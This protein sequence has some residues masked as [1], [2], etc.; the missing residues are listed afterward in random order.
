MKRLTSLLL[1]LLLLSGLTGCG[2]V[3]VIGGADGPTGFVPVEG[4]YCYDL[5]SVVLYLELVIQ[6]E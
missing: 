5:E 4:E 6:E 2:D 1:S 3:G